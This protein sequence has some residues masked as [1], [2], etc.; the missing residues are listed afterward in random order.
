MVVQGDGLLPEEAQQTTVATNRDDFLDRWGDG[1]ETDLFR[2]L[3]FS[4]FGRSADHGLSRIPSDVFLLLFLRVSQNHSQP[5]P[6][7]PLH[8]KQRS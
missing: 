1:G 4:I 3:W 2:V 5:I 6:T 7:I 8:I